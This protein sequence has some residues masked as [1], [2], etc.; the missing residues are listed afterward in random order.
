MD[1]FLTKPVATAALFAAIDRLVFA[2]GVSRPANVDHEREIL[3]DPA[4]VLTGCG[5]NADGL[6]MMCQGFK[7]YAPAQ[8]A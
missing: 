2:P 1:D 3:L 7:T 8:L 6:R 4:A 5:D